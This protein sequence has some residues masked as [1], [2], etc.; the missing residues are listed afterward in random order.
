MYEDFGCYVGRHGHPTRKAA[1]VRWEVKAVRFAERGMHVLL[2]SASGGFVEV[3]EK[4]TGRLVQVVEGVDMRLL[5]TGLVP[6]GAGTGTGHAQQH[7]AGSS[8]GEGH[9]EG[10]GPGGDDTVP[11]LVS[12]LGKKN[13]KNGQS[14]ELFE[15]VKTAE[16]EFGTGDPEIP[17]DYDEYDQ[18][19]GQ[20]RQGQDGRWA[21]PSPDFSG[22]SSPRVS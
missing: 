14:I 20:Q 2:F 4:R 18:Q 11:L 21:E 7:G 5:N 13:D 19:Q 17:F 3:R 8:L 22:M 16:I 12:R 1:S 10:P 6:F 9:G 15:L